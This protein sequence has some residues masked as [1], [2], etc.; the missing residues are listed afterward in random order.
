LAPRAL[1][2]ADILGLKNL[3]QTLVSDADSEVE[4]VIAAAPG[5]LA[6][7][8]VSPSMSPLASASPVMGSSYSTAQ[9][10]EDFN[11][12][13]E[14]F[15]IQDVR[16]PQD[17]NVNLTQLELELLKMSRRAPLAALSVSAAP[18]ENADKVLIP[19]PAPVPDKQ[20]FELKPVASTSGSAAKPQISRHE[21]QSAP[22]A[23]APVPKVASTTRISAVI[24]RAPSESAA[25]AP[26]A[27][28]ISVSIPS[29]L[30][31]E[32]AAASAKLPTVSHS[33]VA[34]AA[35][36]PATSV[37]SETTERVEMGAALPR[38]EGTGAEAVEQQTTGLGIT[39]HPVFA[40]HA[41]TALDHDATAV[42][43]TPAASLSGAAEL[44]DLAS[45][46]SRIDSAPLTSVITS[47]SA[48][49]VNRVPQ[50]TP[51][52]SQAAPDTQ[53]SAPAPAPA[54]SAQK[55]GVQGSAI[56]SFLLSIQEKSAAITHVDPP[57]PAEIIHQQRVSAVE[58]IRQRNALEQELRRKQH[59]DAAPSAYQ[60]SSSKNRRAAVVATRVDDDESD[61]EQDSGRIFK[62]PNIV[63]VSI[64]DSQTC[65]VFLKCF[66]EI[67]T[68]QHVPI[69]ARVQCSALHVRPIAVHDVITSIFMCCMRKIPSAL[70]NRLQV[71]TSPRNWRVWRY[72]CRR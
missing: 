31:N 30:F 55:P 63:C 52:A 7:E 67:I 8:G 43:S 38:A 51:H 69:I 10:V 22:V 45:V 47:A 1:S 26:A 44:S 71:S 48:P 6:A 17:V 54:K 37:A 40:S 19:D 61:E 64:A 49:P 14:S 39:A 29:V 72:R 28:A 9:A 13:L 2:S 70:L 32:T 20:A 5:H 34:D 68:K 11:R 65:I 3:E 15:S 25:A 35:A 41:S 12:F 56:R 18:I 36:I 50:S 42:S 59:D 53:P 60:V 57:S 4:Q 46:S 66:S 23:A 24:P 21:A 16:K 58:L 62:N 33:G 27:A